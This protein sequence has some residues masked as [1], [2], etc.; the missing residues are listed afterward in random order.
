MEGW[1]DGRMVARDGLCFQSR[2]IRDRSHI[3]GRRFERRTVNEDD[4]VPN[5]QNPEPQ[6]PNPEG[7]SPQR[8]SAAQ[9]G[10]GEGMVVMEWLPMREPPPR[11]RDFGTSCVFSRGVEIGVRGRSPDL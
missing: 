2:A 4:C 6:T 7:D 11:I 8:H 3:V 9:R 1:K 5:F 10:M